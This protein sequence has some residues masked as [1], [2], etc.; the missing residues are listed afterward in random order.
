MLGR[1]NRMQPRRALVIAALAVVLVVAGCGNGAD[2]GPSSA[3]ASGA[4]AG[5]ST[6]EEPSP[7]SPLPLAD[8][9]TV[10]TT[11]STRGPENSSTMSVNDEQPVDPL[12]ATT[13]PSPTVT[14]AP[15]TSTTIAAV[16]D[17]SNVVPAQVVET[18][19]LAR[20]GGDRTRAW[21]LRFDDRL[22]LDVAQGMALEARRYGISDDSGALDLFAEGSWVRGD[23]DECADPASYGGAASLMEFMLTGGLFGDYDPDPVSPDGARLTV[24]TFSGALGEEP[25]DQIEYLVGSSRL[26]PMAMWEQRIIDELPGVG[27]TEYLAAIAFEHPCG[28]APAGDCA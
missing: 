18:I 19:D 23:C 20:P 4:T 22:T 17:W 21:L 16:V 14:T 24:R 2:D 6:T 26:G 15:T 10:T 3:S 25:L 28:R 27:A 9:D 8:D 5:P 12:V 13:T 1:W 11:S 7:G